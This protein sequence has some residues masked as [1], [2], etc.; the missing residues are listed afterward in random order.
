[1][2]SPPTY[3]EMLD[4]LS[5][6]LERLT[7][8]EAAGR[9]PWGG[10]RIGWL[11]VEEPPA[12]RL[13]IV[14]DLHGDSSSLDWVLEK[15]GDDSLIVFLGDY[16]DR[17]PP[18]GQVDVFHRVLRLYLE[19]RAVALRGNHEPPEDLVPVPHDYPRALIRLYGRERAAELY[20]LSQR[21]FDKL[22]AALVV[23][24]SFLAVHGG[25]P[26][27]GLDRD[28]EGYLWGGGDP[29]ILEELLWNDPTEKDVVSAPNPRGAGSL[30]GKKVTLA[31]LEK[32][33][34]QVIVRGHEVPYEGY[35]W[36]HGGMVLTLF[37]RTG[38]P[39]F[40]IAR[41]L[42]LIDSCRLA[43]LADECIIVDYV[44]YRVDYRG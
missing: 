4:T 30:W 19:G 36:N 18:E 39:Y 32:T 38:A 40:N 42:A 24:G 12:R 9:S 16:V 43:P 35:R 21:V 15:A 26:T 6:A 3:N 33:G 13:A 20:W 10:R 37:S 28:L 29:R 1:M 44:D 22:P 2:P 34:A 25:P 27:I 11:L 31:A 14:G 8:E 41:A 7:R 23:R 17:G 5:E